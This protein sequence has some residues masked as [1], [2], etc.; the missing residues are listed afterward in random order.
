MLSSACFGDPLDH[1]ARIRKSVLLGK[2]SPPGR[3]D[4]KALCSYATTR[5][6]A[7]GPMRSR[8]GPIRPDRNQSDFVRLETQKMGCSVQPWPC[9]AGL[10]QYF[11][12]GGVVYDDVL[13]LREQRLKACGMDF[14]FASQRHHTS[15]DPLTKLFRQN[16]LAAALV[17]CIF[18]RSRRLFQAT[19][20]IT[21]HLPIGR[22]TLQI[23]HLLRDLG[24]SGRSLLPLSQYVHPTH[25]LQTQGARV[26]TN[27]LEH[28]RCKD[29][30]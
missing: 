26:C 2:L 3:P 1:H 24:P 30:Q 29:Q 19:E 25:H 4:A 14:H 20:S 11:S 13:L 21:A 8:A 5:L 10:L 22:V 12:D 9:G 27:A 17:V 23:T 16:P 6:N 7:I 28:H 18:R 15:D